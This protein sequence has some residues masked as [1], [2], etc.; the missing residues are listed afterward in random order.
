MVFSSM[1]LRYDV[2]HLVANREHRIS[3]RFPMLSP[4]GLSGEGEWILAMERFGMCSA[5]FEVH[6]LRG[7][8]GLTHSVPWM[9]ARVEV[10]TLGILAGIVQQTGIV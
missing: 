2:K 10:Q 6:L 3:V 8:L 5:S 1:Q 4:H 7:G 9:S